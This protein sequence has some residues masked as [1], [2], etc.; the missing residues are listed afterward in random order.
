MRCEDCGTEAKPGDQEQPAQV[1]QSCGGRLIEGQP[2]LPEVAPFPI[3]ALERGRL[4]L[5]AGPGEAA[6][7]RLEVRVGNL[8]GT[9]PIT[10][11]VM[12]LGRRDPAGGARPDVDLSADDAVS[13][14][15]AELR[16]RDGAAYLVDLGSTNGTIVNG[17]PIT[18]GEERMLSDGDVIQLGER[19][20]LTMRL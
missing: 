20:V 7:P 14:R 13:R 16:M 10:K 8:A 1:C 12:V 6:G 11:P 2:D 3:K 5:A 19:C 17:D 9:F 15:H 18:P 4:E